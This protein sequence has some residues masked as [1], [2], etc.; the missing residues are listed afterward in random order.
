MQC[1]RQPD[2]LPWVHF[3]LRMMQLTGTSTALPRYSPHHCMLLLGVCSYIENWLGHL[4]SMGQMM[5]ADSC[6]QLAC[7]ALAE[8]QQQ[9]GGAGGGRGSIWRVRQASSCTP[10]PCCSA[11]GG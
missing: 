3:S 9:G 11:V 2:A 4:S 6:A 1:H 8:W 10:Q 5:A 7:M